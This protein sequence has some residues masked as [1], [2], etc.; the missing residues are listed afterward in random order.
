[1]DTDDG[2]KY[3]T[4]KLNADSVSNSSMS[5]VF[6]ND[7]SSGASLKS[8]QRISIPVIEVRAASRA[9]HF[10]FIPVV[11]YILLVTVHIVI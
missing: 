4:Y 3:K 9:A 8:G 7:T 5:W 11:V 1:M 2:M 10:L 6:I